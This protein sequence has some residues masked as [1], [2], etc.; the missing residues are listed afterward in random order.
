RAGGACGWVWLRPGGLERKCRGS[1]SVPRPRTVRPCPLL[2]NPR[3]K[4]T[5]RENTMRFRNLQSPRRGNPVSAD[6][7]RTVDRAATAHMKTPVGAGAGLLGVAVDQ[8]KSRL[9]DVRKVLSCTF[10]TRFTRTQFG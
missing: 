6:T 1:S 5:R 9:P 10:R 8:G 3:A 7:G 2:S 4:P